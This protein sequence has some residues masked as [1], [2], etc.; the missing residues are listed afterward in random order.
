MGSQCFCGFV[1]GRPPFETAFG[2]ALRGN[3][4]PLAIIGEDSNR[5]AAAAAEDEQA[6]GKRIGFEFLAAE[7]G[8]RI[9]PLPSVNG[10]DR[11]QNAQL[12]CDLD[13]DADS[14]NSRLS[15]VR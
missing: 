15:V 4:K 2:K 14:N 5:L 9:D 8:E 7:L 10:F 1:A 13:Q 3:P 12:R 6:A 11:N